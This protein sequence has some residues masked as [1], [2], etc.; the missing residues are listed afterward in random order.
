MFSLS[1]V[2]VLFFSL[3]SQTNHTCVPMWVLCCHYSLVV[4]NIISCSVLV[5]KFTFK[6][7]R[8][9][10]FAG[11]RLLFERQKTILAKLCTFNAFSGR[12]TLL[13]YGFLNIPE[14]QLIFI[15]NCTQERLFGI[16]EELW[17]DAWWFN[18][19]LFMHTR[20]LTHILFNAFSHY[21]NNDD[22]DHFFFSSSSLLF[23]FCFCL[24][25]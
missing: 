8:S 11:T 5:Q 9:S 17:T 10:C 19:S 13:L 20:T 14:H 21:N 2:V 4:S 16:E 23:W 22:D 12:L 1:I 25:G 7:P 15:H 18:H 6:R 24:F 3:S